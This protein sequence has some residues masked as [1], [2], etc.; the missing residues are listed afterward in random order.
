MLQDKPKEDKFVYSISAFIDLLGFSSH[1]NLANNDLRTEVG[2]L[3]FTRLRIIEK[4]INI[5]EKEKEQFPNL[6]PKDFRWMRINDAL[7]FGMD[8]KDVIQSSIGK[9]KLEI[10]GANPLQYDSNEY[11]EMYKKV[12]KEAQSVSKFLGLISRV[13]SY[14]NQQEYDINMPGC[15]T[16]IAGGLRYKYKD[17][18]NRNDFY[19]I[20]FSFTNAYLVSERGSKDGFEGN[21]IFVEDSVAEICNFDKY[22]SK[23]LSYA[24][25]LPEEP[26]TNPY[27]SKR[28]F[29]PKYKVTPAIPVSLFRKK[30]IFRKLNPTPL[31]NLQLL[32]NYMQSLEMENDSLAYNVIDCLKS[33]TISLDELNSLDA[34]NM[35]AL[36]FYSYTLVANYEGYIK[37]MF[38]RVQK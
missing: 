8:V 27:E 20:N 23:V 9:N 28:H 24:K 29:K 16:I 3:A 30:Y 11:I 32:D 19:S 4:A 2:K 21:N 35:K 17:T 5:F 25:F 13:H 34:P 10:H 37:T 1:L 38:K 6:Y 15:R 22:V 7:I 36:L 18:K 26:N 14:I 33:E 12:G 31:N